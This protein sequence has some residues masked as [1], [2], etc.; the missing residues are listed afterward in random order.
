MEGGQ[1]V[2]DR[3]PAIR[4][5]LLIPALVLFAASLLALPFVGWAVWRAVAEKFSG[6][7]TSMRSWTP[8]VTGCVT[9][10]LMANPLAVAWLLAYFSVPSAERA[11]NRP[12]RRSILYCCLLPLAMDATVGLGLLAAYLFLTQA[13]GGHGSGYGLALGIL[14]IGALV[15]FAIVPTILVWLATNVAATARLWRSLRGREA[16]VPAPDLA[17]GP[18]RAASLGD[19]G[20][21][22]DT[23]PPD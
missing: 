12:L 4:W 1:R 21:P 6:G 15:I 3:P 18:G 14:L 10:F 17:E 5:G 11:R 8:I 2:N 23:P 13:G 20:L 16:P 9:F 19:P 22:E 7:D